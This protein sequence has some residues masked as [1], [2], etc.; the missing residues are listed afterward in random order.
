MPLL[1][2]RFREM[3]RQAQH[4]KWGCHSG[5]FIYCHSERSRGISW[6][7]VLSSSPR[8]GLLLFKYCAARAKWCRYSNNAP[9]DVST[10]LRLLNMTGRGCVVSGILFSVIPSVVEES[11]GNEFFLLPRGGVLFLFKH[12]AARAK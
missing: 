11:R 4:D 7:R 6:K 5:H 10:A 8:R 1:K 3:F 12:C 2:Q 9:R